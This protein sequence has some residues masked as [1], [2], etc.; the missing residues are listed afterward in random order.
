MTKMGRPSKES[1]A[2]EHVQHRDTRHEL[3]IAMRVK[4]GI[5][6]ELAP[7]TYQA[8]RGKVN[9]MGVTMKSVVEEFARLVAIDDPAAQQIIASMQKRHATEYVDTKDQANRIDAKALWDYIAMQNE[10]AEK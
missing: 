9:D 10:E 2:L 6:I 7:D 3:D 1:K 5:H 8:F 4:K